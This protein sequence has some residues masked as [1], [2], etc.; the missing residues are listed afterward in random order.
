MTPEDILAIPPASTSPLAALSA[1]ARD[2]FFRLKPG[3]GLRLDPAL[4]YRP[5]AS[6]KVVGRGGE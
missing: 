2:A 5:P 4:D 3:S 6:I 1:D